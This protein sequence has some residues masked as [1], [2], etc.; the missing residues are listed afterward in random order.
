MLRPGE[1][2]TVFEASEFTPDNKVT[3]SILMDMLDQLESGGYGDHEI[4]IAPEGKP[5]KVKRISLLQGAFPVV[6]D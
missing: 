2:R 4:F 1:P 6:I 5:C 3:V